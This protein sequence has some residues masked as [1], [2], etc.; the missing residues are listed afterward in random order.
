[1][2]VLKKGKMNRVS[3]A[4]TSLVRPIHEHGYVC[5]DQCTEG[6]INTLD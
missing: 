3:L 6:Q 4:Y 5:W 1:M 2:H